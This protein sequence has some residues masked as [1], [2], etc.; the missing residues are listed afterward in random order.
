MKGKG[1]WVVVGAIALIIVCALIYAASSDKKMPTYQQPATSTPSTN[2]QPQSNRTGSYVDYSA[3]ALSGAEGRRWI[4]FHAGWCP[5]C[6]ALEQDI[7]TDGVPTGIT[8]FKANYDSETDIK[9][10]Y[11]VTL[12]TTIVEVDENGNEV[13]KFVAYDDPTLDAVLSAMLEQ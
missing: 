8:I 5:Q 4:F 12:Q 3:E 7:K 9:K 11:G 13:K 10:K 2:N 6:R 1:L